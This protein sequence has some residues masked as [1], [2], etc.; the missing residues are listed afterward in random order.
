MEVYRVG[1]CN[2]KER[3]V[4]AL[5]RKEGGCYSWAERRHVVSS[6]FVF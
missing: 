6:L 1:L 5:G 3:Y 4:I 2:V